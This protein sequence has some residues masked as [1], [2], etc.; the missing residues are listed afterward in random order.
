MAAG[1]KGGSS[2]R[3]WAGLAYAAV[4]VAIV[5]VVASKINRLKSAGKVTADGSG[6]TVDDLLDKMDS[7]EKTIA[8]VVEK[9]EYEIDQNNAALLEGERQKAI[10]VL[11]AELE[12]TKSNQPI[13]AVAYSEIWFDGDRAAGAGMVRA[14]ID[15]Y[16]DGLVFYRNFTTGAKTEGTRWHPNPDEHPEIR[17]LWKYMLNDAALKKWLD[18]RGLATIDDFGSYLYLAVRTGRGDG[19]KIVGQ[20]L[21]ADVQALKPTGTGTGFWISGNGYLLTNEHVVR[22]N[23]PV[24][25]VRTEEDRRLTRAEIIGVDKKNDLA[26]LRTTGAPSP[27]WI[28]LAP[29]QAE[30]G[31]DVFAIGFPEAAILGTNSKLEYGKITATSGIHDN[32][33]HYQISVNLLPGN[34]GGALVQLLGG[35]PYVVGVVSSGIPDMGRVFYAIK[36]GVVRDFLARSGQAAAIGLKN[37]PP[38]DG[39]IGDAIA[40]VR[41]A[42]CMVI[43][44]SR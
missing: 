41:R 36:S 16:E 19:S 13:L 18:E 35:K 37:T 22:G 23:N 31:A 10:N 29:S 14:L 7:T 9:V 38:D 30:Q 21:P 4:L 24:V 25:H 39:A 8:T 27:H 12:K 44:R 28:A 6:M 42:S 5:F 26:L 17:R 15:A 3:I 43:V 32:P 2:A 11:E 40:Q 1:K 34:S 20:H 33:D